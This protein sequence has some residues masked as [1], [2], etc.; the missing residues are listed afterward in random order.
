MVKDSG[1]GR[2][3]LGV[4]NPVFDGKHVNDMT[5][6]EL[7]AFSEWIVKQAKKALEVS[8]DPA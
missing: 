3:N 7:T 6:D 5:D 2:K 1:S 8:D 4:F